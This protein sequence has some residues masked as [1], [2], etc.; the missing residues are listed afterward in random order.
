MKIPHRNRY[1][2]NKRFSCNPTNKI[3]I[4]GSK[5]EDKTVESVKKSQ[6]EKELR[7]FPDHNKKTAGY[8][9]KYRRNYV[10]RK[11]VSPPKKQA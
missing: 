4:N 10:E 6:L 2:P 5:L 11:S 3:I 9:L 7:N 8:E 1:R